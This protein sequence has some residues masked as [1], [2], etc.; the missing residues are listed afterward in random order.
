MK[1]EIVALVVGI[2]TGAIFSLSKL[3]LPAPPTLAGIAG[4]VGIFVGSKLVEYA[5][6]FF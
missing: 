5:R 4:I 3:P 2:V 6:N 1:V